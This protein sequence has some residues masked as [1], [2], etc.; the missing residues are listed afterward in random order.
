MGVIVKRGPIMCVA[1]CVVLVVLCVMCVLCV[2][3]GWKEQF[4]KLLIHTCVLSPRLSPRLSPSLSLPCLF[5]GTD[6]EERSLFS[7]LDMLCRLFV[8]K[9]LSEWLDWFLAM[10]YVSDDLSRG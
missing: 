1:V 9:S 5:A 4:E 10:G 6:R 7:S 3:W 8:L 2:L